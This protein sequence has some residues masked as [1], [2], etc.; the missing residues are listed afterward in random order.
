MKI[1]IDMMGGDIGVK[2]TI[3]ALIKFKKDYPDVEII[4]VGRVEDLKAVEK[5]ATIID[6]RDIVN[7]EATPLEVLRAKESSLLKAI[8]AVDRKS[9]V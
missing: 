4:A 9:V 1:V 3:P 8:N 7:V 6:A 5:Y 2:A